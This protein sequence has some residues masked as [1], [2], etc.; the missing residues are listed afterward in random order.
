MVLILRESTSY[1]FVEI[2]ER[3]VRRLW[4]L[5]IK[6]E[7]GDLAETAFDTIVEKT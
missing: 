2:L 1:S 6:V 4:M 7:V 3:F 5:D